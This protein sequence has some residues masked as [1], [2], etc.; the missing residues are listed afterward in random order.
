MSFPP[1]PPPAP[2][3]PPED[4]WFRPPPPPGQIPPPPS[5][6]A[7]PPPPVPAGV[8]APSAYPS[9]GYGYDAQTQDDPLIPT[10]FGS[11][12]TKVFAAIGRSWK[13]LALVHLLIFVPQVLLGIVFA[14]RLRTVTEST[15]P[16][17]LF[18]DLGATAGGGLLLGMLSFV[19]QAVASVASAHIISHDAAGVATGAPL[20]D[21]VVALRFGWSK[22]GRMIGWSILSTLLTFVGF[23]F[24]ILPGVWL[25]VIFYATLGGVVAFERGDVI[26][27]CME[28]VKTRFWPTFGRIFILWLMTSVGGA[29]AGAVGIGSG[30]GFGGFSRAGSASSSVASVVFTQLVAAVIAVPIGMLRSAGSVVTYAELRSKQQYLNAPILAAEAA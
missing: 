22:L 4:G 27:R 23:I 20:T 6:G 26:S 30:I 28:L 14:L 5:N 17:R 1:P 9:Y 12:F 24:C 29:I 19:F 25:A 18:Q 8:S 11:W 21:W 15:S 2:P 7:F 16:N 10:D 3:P 13:A